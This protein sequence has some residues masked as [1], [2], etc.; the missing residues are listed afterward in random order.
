MASGGRK[1]QDLTF[2]VKL[3][4]SHRHTSDRAVGGRCTKTLSVG[5]SKIILYCCFVMDNCKPMK[6]L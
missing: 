3:H 5:V 2:D 4:N 1:S 6:Q